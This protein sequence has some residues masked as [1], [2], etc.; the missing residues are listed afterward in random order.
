MDTPFIKRII[1]HF[2][3][4]QLVAIHLNSCNI[5]FNMVILLHINSP[6]WGSVGFL[7]NR[8]KSRTEILLIFI[9]S[10]HF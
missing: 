7:C 3:D 5:S 4:C 10:S 6:F 8:R 9:R 2:G 1:I